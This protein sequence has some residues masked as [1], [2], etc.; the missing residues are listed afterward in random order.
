MMAAFREI[1]YRYGADVIVVLTERI[2][3]KDQLPKWGVICPV[4]NCC[5]W[6]SLAVCFSSIMR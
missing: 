2:E 3:M 5:P 6:C 1:V 4:L